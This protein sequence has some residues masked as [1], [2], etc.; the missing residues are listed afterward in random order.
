MGLS[1]GES[2]GVGF[3]TAITTAL[4]SWG[5][6]LLTAFLQRGNE[7]EKYRRE[8]ALERYTEFI[9]LVTQDLNRAKEVQSIA[10][11]SV[12]KERLGELDKTRFETLNRLGQVSMVIVMH[13]TDSGLAQQVL[14]I[15]KLQPFEPYIYTLAWGQPG[16]DESFQRH[17]AAITRLEEKTAEL[18]VAVKTAYG[19]GQLAKSVRDL[20]S[21]SAGKVDEFFRALATRAK[22]P[23]SKD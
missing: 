10:V 3:I 19:T 23:P 6:Q 9:L 11:L 18:A 1:F 20:L 12:G 14:E 5:A 4:L 2:I 7:R 15:A 21:I 8:K 22:Q 17:Q 16:Y 13:E